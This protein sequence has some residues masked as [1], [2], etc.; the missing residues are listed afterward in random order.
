MGELTGLT[1]LAG[2]RYR[3]RGDLTFH[4]VTRAVEGEVGLRLDGTT[5]HLTGRQVFDIR[6]FR[7]TP[8]R[9]LLIRVHPD[10]DVH[11]DLVAEED[12]RRG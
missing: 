4:G 3:L 1:H 9:I 12:P 8:P 5:L 7:V 6:D 11:L 2:E 10:V